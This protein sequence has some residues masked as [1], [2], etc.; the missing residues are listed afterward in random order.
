MRYPIVWC[1]PAGRSYAGSL[2]LGSDRLTLDGV[3]E[4]DREVVELAYRDL[5]AVRM[6]AN[7]A[8]RLG[9]RPTL[10]LDAKPRRRFRIAAVGGAGVMREVADTLA[11]ELVVA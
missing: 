1:E 10:L 4:G 3:S 8:E 6:A 2:D 11:H 5:E 7:R 9:G